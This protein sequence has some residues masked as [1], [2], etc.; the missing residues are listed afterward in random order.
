MKF[1]PEALLIGIIDLFSIMLPGAL[2]TALLKRVV[3]PVLFPAVFPQHT[4]ETAGWVVFPFASYLLGHFIFLFG[5]FLD[6]LAYDAAQIVRI[7]ADR[8]VETHGEQHRNS[9]RGRVGARRC[10][11]FP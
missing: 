7:G 6:D 11:D 4:S 10:G 2:A 8:S 3:E 1:E 5:S 9:H